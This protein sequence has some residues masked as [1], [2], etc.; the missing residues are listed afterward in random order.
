LRRKDYVK[1]RF[2]LKQAMAI[3]PGNPE[4][5]LRLK[6]LDAAAPK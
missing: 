5:D 6:Q 1:A 2:Y 3:D 4:L